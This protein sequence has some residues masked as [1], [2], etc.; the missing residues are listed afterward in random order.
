[1]NFKPGLSLYSLSDSTYYKVATNDYIF[2]KPEYPFVWGVDIVDTGILIR[3]VLEN[4]LRN[5]ATVY[6]SFSINNPIVL[7]PLM[8]EDKKNILYA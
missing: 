3:D 1:M 4:V 7:T 8:W 6:S 5:Q 2:D